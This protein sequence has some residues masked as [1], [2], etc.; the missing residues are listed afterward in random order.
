MRKEPY[1]RHGVAMGR[2]FTLVEVLIAVMISAVLLVATA[3]VLRASINSFTANQA[4]ADTLQRARITM[5]RI[6]QQIR[7]G[8]DHLPATSAKQAGFLSGSTVTDSGISFVDDRGQDIDYLY[9]PIA[10][11]L[12][13]RV[14]SGTAR[15]LASNVSTFSVRMVP[16]RS[17]SA[18]KTGG[19]YDEVERITVTLSVNAVVDGNEMQGQSVTL[20]ESITPRARLWN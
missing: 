2:G 10:A 12:S 15:R 7:A 1:R 5:M 18:I 14:N 16:M 9:D 3:A 17:P 6:S 8:T 20:S 11:T 19:V 13:I 4:S